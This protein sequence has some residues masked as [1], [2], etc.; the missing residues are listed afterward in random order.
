MLWSIDLLQPLVLPLKTRENTLQHT[1]IQG[2]LLVQ[3]IIEVLREPEQQVLNH[4]LRKVQLYVHNHVQP[5]VHLLIPDR[6]LRVVVLR[7]TVDQVQLLVVGLILLRQEHRQKVIVLRQ[8][9][10]QE[11]V[12]VIAEVLLQEAEVIVVE[13]LLVVQAAQQE[14]VVQVEVLLVE[15]N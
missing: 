3:N 1:I 7:H 13:V 6:V 8:E 10:R 5:E 9:H 4:V 2:W 12:L 11:V 15:D 14:V